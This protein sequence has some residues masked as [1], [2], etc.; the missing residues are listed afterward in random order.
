M[1][2]LISFKEAKKLFENNDDPQIVINSIWE[3][4]WNNA[5]NNNDITV[6]NNMLKNHVRI[7]N[8]EP[9]GNGFVCDADRSENRIN[10]IQ[11]INDKINK[12]LQIQ[13]R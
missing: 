1:K 12:I 10:I 9:S 13:E 5:K 6:L 7:Y 11:F 2:K 4:H 8:G 3:S